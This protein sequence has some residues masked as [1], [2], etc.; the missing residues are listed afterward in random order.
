MPLGW[1]GGREQGAARKRRKKTKDLAK[2]RRFKRKT[3]ARNWVIAASETST[4]L[5]DTLTSFLE[6]RIR[7]FHKTAA[8]ESFSSSAYGRFMKGK[9][10]ARKKRRGNGSRKVKKNGRRVRVTKTRM[11]A[12]ATKRRIQKI[13][14]GKT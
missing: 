10:S 14:R 7:Q 8:S 1:E 12:E 9:G 13:Q 5:T 2:R 3:K 6:K 11:R 4:T